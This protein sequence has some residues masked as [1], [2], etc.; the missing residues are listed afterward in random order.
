MERACALPRVMIAAP[1]GRSGKTVVVAGLLRALRNRGVEVQPFK[2]GPDYIDP[3][4]HSVAAGR[5]SRNLDC[6]FMDAGAIRSVLVGASAG[7]QIALVEG[8]M[9]LFD[10]SDLAGSSSSAEVAKQTAT[11]VIL[12]LDVTRMTRTAAALVRGCMDFDPDVNVVGVILNRVH[13]TRHEARLREAI[14]HYCGIPVVGII[15]EDE[16]LCLGDRHLGLVSSAEVETAD[17]FVE[18]VASVIEEHVDL[19]VLLQLAASAPALE[20]TAPL[21]PS[22]GAPSRESVERVKIAVVRDEAFNF[23][24]EENLQALEQAGAR[25]EYVDS[26]ADPALP[27]DAC[28]IYIGG[29]FPE[30]FAR[31]LQA[32]A[33]FRESVRSGIENGMAGWA[34]CGGLMYLARTLRTGGS[35]FDMAGVFAFDVQMEAERQGHGY[36]VA[37]TC[38]NHPWLSAGIV[39]KGHEHHYSHVVD[40]ADDLT[41]S[42]VDRR[43]CGIVDKRDGVCRNRCVAG[44]VHVNALASPQWAPGFVAAARAYETRGTG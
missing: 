12:V 13:G 27:T 31:E 20:H 9:G 24:Y 36:V 42:L 25:L 4:W 33:S 30:V 8:A 2:K 15:P 23:Y 3:G 7:A 6:F 28:G 5:C 1:H 11:P 38:A 19:D 41:F 17:S 39:L 37:T 44:Y 29:G 21:F 22:V 43:G 18:S 32:N 14:E 10:G 34:E 35:S 16:R 26:L 40:A